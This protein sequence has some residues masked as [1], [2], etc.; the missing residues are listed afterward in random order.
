MDW[1]TIVITLVSALLGIG[2]I[3]AFAAKYGPNVSKWA[4]LAKDATETIADIAASLAKGP[5]TAAEISQIQADAAQF[6]ADLAV[7]LSK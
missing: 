4:T 3:A 2:G 5:L 1:T 7:A 6:K